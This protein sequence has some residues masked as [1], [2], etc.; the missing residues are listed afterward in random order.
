MKNHWYFVVNPVSGSG[1][2]MKLWNRIQVLLD[3]SNI[4]YSFGISTFHQHAIE[5][6]SQKHQEGF[7]N[8]IGIGGDGT[9]NEIVNAIINS[10]NNSPSKSTISQLSVGTGNDWVKNYDEPLTEFNLVSRLKN[11][12]TILH[13]IGIVE[14]TQPELKQYFINVAGAGIDGRVV[15]ELEKLSVSGKKSKLA[16]VQSMLKSLTRFEAPYG[17]INIDNKN[18]YEGRTLLLAASKGQYFGGGMHI[19]PKALPNSGTLDLT[20]VKKD[21]N[22][23]VFPQLYKLFNGK[24]ETATFVEKYIHSKA[25]FTSEFP[26]PIQADGE[27]VGESK[28]VSFS[29]LKHAVHV[30]V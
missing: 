17:K 20:L 30:L 21:T 12:K 29:V 26:I 24:I 10:E 2:G 16:Y 19:S 23:I 6:I 25:E 15:H 22:L 11:N 3:A 13:D 28:H 1:K 7:R 4:E 5:L 8:F 9:L 27:F 18:V 14:S